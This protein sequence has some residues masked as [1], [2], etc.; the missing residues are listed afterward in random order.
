MA[1]SKWLVSLSDGSTV[2]EQWVPGEP[3]PWQRLLGTLSSTGLH[4]T[5]L[6]LQVGGRTYS[7]MSNAEGY[8]QA[9]LVTT[10]CGGPSVEERHGLGYITSDRLH[11]MWVGAETGDVWHEIKSIPQGGVWRRS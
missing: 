2:V 7:S 4:I 1:C 6:R 9:R 8:Y 10:S 11:M 3:S 5:Q